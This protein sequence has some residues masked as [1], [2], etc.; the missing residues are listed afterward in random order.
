MKQHGKV[1]KVEHWSGLLCHHGIW[2]ALH[3]FDE[4]VRYHEREIIQ[5]LGP[6]IEGV[7]EQDPKGCSLDE[8][9]VDVPCFNK[10]NNTDWNEDTRCTLWLRKKND[11]D[12]WTWEE[13]E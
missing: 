11:K 12:W 2:P 8:R 10:A 13:E 1:F 4:G 5:D 7:W 3:E 9:S 6:E